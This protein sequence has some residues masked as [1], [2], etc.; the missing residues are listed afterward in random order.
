MLTPKPY[1]ERLIDP[2]IAG[3]LQSFGAV[4]VQGPKWCGKT[5]SSLHQARS[6]TYMQDSTGNF[7]NRNLAMI[8]PN[9]VLEGETPHLIDEWQDVPAIW[10]AVR[11]AV[12][13]DPQKG[14]FLLTGSSTPTRKG[15]LHSGAGRIATLNMTTMSLFETGDSTGQVRLAEL[16]EG[17]LPPTKTDPAPLPELI[18]LAIRGGWPANLDSDGGLEVTTQYLQSV[19]TDD[20]Y[21]VDG[22]KRDLEKLEALVFS[23]ARSTA[24]TVSNRKLLQDMKKYQDVSVHENTVG[25]YLDVLAKLFLIWEQPSFHPNL[26]SSRRILRAPKRHFADYSLAVAALRATPQMLAQDLQTFGYIFESLVEHDLNIYAQA[27][28]ARLYHFRDEKGNELDAVVQLPDGRWAAFE[29]KL[30]AYRVDEGAQNLLRIAQLLDSEAQGNPA[31][32]APSFLAV[33]CGTG[34]I[35]YT[36]K[37]GVRVIPITALRD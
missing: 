36:R 10:D 25:D 35:A 19:I 15:V 6:V 22:V 37:D 4:C 8:D 28:G 7:S 17:E 34:D 1:R 29:I 24:T 21:R 16:F 32:L 27:I 14:R 18:R 26:R 11:F 12:D 20:A 13:Q 9:L 23:L 2:Q 3:L 31:Y 5:W 30:G 33:I